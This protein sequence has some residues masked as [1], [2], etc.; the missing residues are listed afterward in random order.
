MQP[1]FTRQ[2]ARPVM[3]APAPVDAPVPVPADAPAPVPADAPAPVDSDDD[4]YDSD[5]DSDSD[6]IDPLLCCHDRLDQ[7]GNCPHRCTQCSACLYTAGWDHF[8]AL[9]E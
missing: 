7:M 3:D 8:E 9:F 2:I 4:S 6:D 5:S 1:Q